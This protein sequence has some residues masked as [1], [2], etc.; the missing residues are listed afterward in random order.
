METPYV[1]FIDAFISRIEKDI[2]FFNYF[3]MIDEQAMDL[4]HKRAKVYL[5]EAFSRIMMECNPSVDFFD[6]DDASETLNFEVNG[7]EVFLVSMLMY[8]SYLSRDISK[9]KIRNVDYTSTD[10]RVFDPSNSRAT[11]MDI[12][13]NVRKQNEELL[14]TYKNTDRMT[15]DYVGV[16]YTRYDLEE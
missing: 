14:D 7:K 1:V 13:N 4:A 12:Y 10:L 11:F 6:Y 8:E 3:M 16:D 2:D 9:I 15:N 5:H